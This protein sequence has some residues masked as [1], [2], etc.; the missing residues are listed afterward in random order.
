MLN[1][2]QIQSLPETQQMMF[3]AV[4]DDPEFGYLRGAIQ[5]S[6]VDEEAD[7]K[8]ASSYS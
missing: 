1:D 3:K 2:D 7:V 6:Y 5:K 8:Y 4:R